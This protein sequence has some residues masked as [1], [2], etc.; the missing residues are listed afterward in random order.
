MSRCTR[1]NTKRG[2]SPDQ[3]QNGGR[4]NANLNASEPKKK[5]KTGRKTTRRG[6]N[7]PTRQI[8]ENASERE[9]IGGDGHPNQFDPDFSESAS[10]PTAV[11][12]FEENDNIVQFEI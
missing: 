6:K 11:A 5:Q 4:D 3:S 12:Q 10:Q 9:A 8:E 2:R 7:T 1:L